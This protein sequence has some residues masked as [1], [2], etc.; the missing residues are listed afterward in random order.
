MGDCIHE[1][2]IAVG[3]NEEVKQLGAVPRTG[4][5]PFVLQT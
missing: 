1:C 5:F 4:W 3:R 2:L